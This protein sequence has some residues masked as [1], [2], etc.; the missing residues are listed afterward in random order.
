MTWLT[1]D[2]ET[3]RALRRIDSKWRQARAKARELPLAAKIEAF[4][5]ADQA[6]DD[7]TA[8]LKASIL[9]PEQAA[10]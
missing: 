8:K 1:D 5:A 10:S 3:A 4:R 2:P 7:A 6:R 9:F